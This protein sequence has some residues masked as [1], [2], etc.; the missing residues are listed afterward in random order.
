[1][2]WDKWWSL[3][4]RYEEAMRTDNSSRPTVMTLHV[5][6]VTPLITEALKAGVKMEDLQTK[7]AT[8]SDKW[9]REKQA[10]LAEEG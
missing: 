8:M 7:F 2:K 6:E 9:E 3:E 1:M 5:C 10:F 4:L